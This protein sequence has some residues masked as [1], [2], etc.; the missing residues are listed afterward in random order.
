MKNTK[1][2]FAALAI[3]MTTFSCIRDYDCECVVTGVSGIDTT[4]TTQHVVSN[5]NKKDAE[6]N[7]EFLGGTNYSGSA[8]LEEVCTLK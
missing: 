5:S 2:L 4:Y 3:S 7:C 8:V 6:A 1:I